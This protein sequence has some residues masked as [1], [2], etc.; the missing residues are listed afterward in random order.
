MKMIS[1]SKDTSF[2][3]QPFT[4]E[5]GGLL[6]FRFDRKAEGILTVGKRRFAVRRGEASSDDNMITR[7]SS[8]SVSYAS[9]KIS[10]SSSSP[11]RA[12]VCES[13]NV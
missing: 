3:A 7:V 1:C 10:G 4:G 9:E 8:M 5:R 2:R 11:T 12:N 13:E 6:I